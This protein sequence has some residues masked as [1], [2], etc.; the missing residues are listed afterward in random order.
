MYK[1]IILFIIVVISGIFIYNS[2]VNKS[3]SDAYSLDA[4]N[5]ELSRKA[6][7]SLSVQD[8][9][10]LYF[11]NNQ[12]MDRYIELNTFLNMKVVEKTPTGYFVAFQF[13]ELNF[14]NIDN[15]NIYK[16]MY[17]KP[18]YIDMKEDGGFEKIHFIIPKKEAKGLRQI[19]SKLEVIVLQKVKYELVESNNF[20]EYKAKYSRNS[21]V[22]IN[23]SIVKYVHMYNVNHKIDL[24][25]SKILAKVSKDASWLD[26]LNF[27][28]HMKL[29]R[30]NKL[31]LNKYSQ[32]QLQKSLSELDLTL[33]IF[34]DNRSRA[35]I[36]SSL[37]AKLKDNK[38]AAA[39]EINALNR[40]AIKQRKI[41]L[42]KLIDELVVGENNAL[43]YELIS[44]Y[45]EAFPKQVKDLNKYIVDSEGEIA[46]NLIAVLGSLKLNEAMSLLDS[47]AKNN[48]FHMNK[49]RALI[50]INGLQEPNA[51]T[52]NTL[53]DISLQRYS[54]DEVDLS[55]TARLALGAVSKKVD[56]MDQEDIVQELKNILL[57]STTIE[58]KNI[59]LL[60]MDNAG[61]KHFIEE[62]L[63]YLNTNVNLLRLDAIKAFKGVNSEKV[64]NALLDQ[65]N[66]KNNEKAGIA[67]MQTL[68]TIQKSTKSVGKVQYALANE[69]NPN[70]INMMDQYIKSA[71]KQ[72][73]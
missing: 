37:K 65:L 14:K 24:L 67:L 4:L 56:K 54:K 47:I 38:K 68:S 11:G 3:F 55:D 28:E 20:G 21:S 52:I 62:V 57:D 50:A 44:Q 1:S 5:L 63:P 22:D 30:K 48:K 71:K 46:M 36:L 59:A 66:V 34:T 33:D 35:E 64:T 29:F 9:F 72:G 43:K 53:R 25:K 69:L 39:E 73:F 13:S 6:K 31:F 32:L 58:E 45:L 12:S 42:K 16:K 2:T 15:S 51:N 10:K 8:K 49:I 60:A 7:Y 26:S 40:E 27:K 17:I 18:F 70:V 23:K 41:T 61:T 19:V